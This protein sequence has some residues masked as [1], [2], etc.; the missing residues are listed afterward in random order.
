[1]PSMEQRDL[2]TLLRD[3]HQWVKMRTRLQHSLQAIALHHALRQGHALWSAAGQQALAAMPLPPY[4]EQR[5]N[6]LLSTQPP[7]TSA[8]KSMT[9]FRRLTNPESVYCSKT[10]EYAL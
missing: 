4:T 5:R 7:G 8:M 2:R 1:M 9:I 10:K 6:E 3:R